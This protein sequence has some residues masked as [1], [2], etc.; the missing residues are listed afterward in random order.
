MSDKMDL[1]FDDETLAHLKELSAEAGLSVEGLIMCVMEQFAN[2]KGGRVYTGRWSGGEE[3]GVKGFRYCI[4]WPFRPGF[5]EA[6]GHEVKRWS[7]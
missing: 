7:E 3:D 6:V 1:V 2:N 4:Q 5:K